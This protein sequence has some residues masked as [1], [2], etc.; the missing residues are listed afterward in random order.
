MVGRRGAELARW[1]KP[2][3]SRDRD[4]DEDE[5]GSAGSAGGAGGAG[6]L[7]GRCLWA[8]PGAEESMLVMEKERRGR[9]ASLAV[10]VVVVDAR[11][12]VEDRSDL[13]ANKA[14]I[15]NGVPG[16]LMK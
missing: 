15:L 11:G 9:T 1:L 3:V 10:S 13:V 14:V 4:E 2:R 8:P 7:A 5:D 16:L 6:V 12:R